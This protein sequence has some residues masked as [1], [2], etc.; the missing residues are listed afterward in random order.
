VNGTYLLD[1]TVA[2]LFDPRR[3]E[4]AAPVI[5][6]L[7]RN[8]RALRISAVTILE[9]EAGLLKLRREGKDKRAGEIETLRDGLTADFA[10]RLL[11]MDAAVAL[12]AARLAEALRP[13]VL[14]WKDLVIAAMARVHGAT[15]L[16]ANLRH[17][18]ATGV[19]ALDP[20]AGL[21]PEA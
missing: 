12:A 14:D 4:R 1:T 6:W 10:E 19:P 5:A 18:A 16:T 13:A 17:F 21:P 9:I 7:R 3:R 8:D 15:V 20:M 2:S 11:P